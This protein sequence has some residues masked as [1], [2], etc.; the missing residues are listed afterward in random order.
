MLTALTGALFWFGRMVI[1]RSTLQ[2]VELPIGIITALIGAPIFIY[3][4]VKRQYNFGGDG[5]KLAVKAQSN[6]RGSADTKDISSKPH[7]GNLS[8]WLG[9]KSTLLKAIYKTL[10]PDSGDIYL[11]EMNILKSSEKSRPASQR[12]QS[13]QWV[14]LWFNSRTDGALGRTPHKGLLEQDTK[15]DHELVTEALARAKCLQKTQLPLIIRW[16]KTAG[17][18]LVPSPKN[19]NL[20]FSMSRPIIWISVTSWKS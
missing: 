6:D 10:K 8:A 4:I 20:W 14:E 15:A 12:R 1:A 18:L 11:G 17:R 16:R 5:M 13:V 2:G 3:I 19:R 7:R 9:G